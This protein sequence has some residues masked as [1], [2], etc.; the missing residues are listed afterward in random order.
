MDLPHITLSWNNSQWISTFP[1]VYLT[2][3]KN[4]FPCHSWF[5][6]GAEALEWWRPQWRVWSNPQEKCNHPIRGEKLIFIL[7]EGHENLLG[8]HY[9]HLVK[10]KWFIFHPTEESKAND[11]T[12]PYLFMPLLPAYDMPSSLPSCL[13]Y[14]IVYHPM[15]CNY[16]HINSLFQ[17]FPKPN[18]SFL[19]IC[20]P[21]GFIRLIISGKA[22]VKWSIPWIYL[23]LLPVDLEP[24]CM[25]YIVFARQIWK[26]KKKNRS[27]ALNG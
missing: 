7:Q 17:S 27:I 3:L 4:S 5:S 19:N 12:H 9:I 21:F 6:G 20:F 25:W 26:K 15:V 16:I 18:L 13:W 1:L 10:G 8:H 22:Y 14:K 23:E 11:G 2:P 24:C